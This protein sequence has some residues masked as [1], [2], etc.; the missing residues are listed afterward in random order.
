M[1]CCSNETGLGFFNPTTFT[2]M[3]ACSPSWD[4][5]IKVSPSAMGSIKPKESMRMIFG[6]VIAYF[7]RLLTSDRFPVFLSIRVINICWV[8]SGPS[9][10]AFS[11]LMLISA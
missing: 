7:A 9:S 1:I 11:G 3:R 8:D 4:T 5:V 2:L 10:T 6:S